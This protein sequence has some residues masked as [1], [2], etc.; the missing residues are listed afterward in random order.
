MK[1]IVWS[2]LGIVPFTLPAAAG[3]E[4]STDPRADYAAYRTYS[5]VEGDPAR[6]PQ[7]RNHLVRRIDE[8]LTAAGLKRVATDG[9]L[10][11]AIHVASESTYQ[12]VGNY[13]NSVTWEYGFFTSDVHGSTEASLVVDL[14]DAAANRAIWQGRYADTLLDLDYGKLTKKVDQVVKK[15]FRDFPPAAKVP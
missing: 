14:V 10:K 3:V 5:W 6:M 9:D 7:I 15:M 11:V 1:W 13:W 8:Q 4:V 12:A 2:I